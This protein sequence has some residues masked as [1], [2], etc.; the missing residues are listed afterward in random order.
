MAL[1]EGHKLVL[2]MASPGSGSIAPVLDKRITVRDK[3]YM[4]IDENISTKNDDNSFPVLNVQKENTQQYINNAHVNFTGREQASPTVVQQANLKGSNVWA[5]LSV[6]NART[7]TN[8]TTNYSYSGNPENEKTGQNFYRYSDKPRTTTNE[9]TNY[10]YSGNPE[11]EKTGQNFYRYSDKPRTTTNETTL[12]SY[13]GDP[14]GTVNSHNQMNRNQYTGDIIYDNKTGAYY[15]PGTSGVTK[16]SSKSS[17]LIENYIPS[18]NGAVNYQQDALNKIGAPLLRPDDD[19]ISTNGPG[20]L[21]RTAPDGSR[22]TQVDK[23]F[24]GEQRINPNKLFS[25]DTRQTATYQISA[26]KNNGLSVYRDLDKT[27]GNNSI[28]TFFIDQNK[29]N[30]SDYNTSTVKKS[31]DISNNY[32]F[33]FGEYGNNKNINRNAEKV[34]NTHNQIDKNIDNPLLFMKTSKNSNIKHKQS[35]GSNNSQNPTNLEYPGLGYSG[36]ALKANK[37]GVY[38]DYQTKKFSNYS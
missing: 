25:E 33:K 1:I 12:Y 9:T 35:D 4:N 36:S 23:A 26:L 38:L 20:T 11:N 24:I 37:D 15:N 19:S 3:S 7:T 28:P 29:N 32:E 30:Y 14:T 8:E 31:K 13:S 21:H 5:N 17:V 18:A 10:S 22:F 34:F 6:F 27:K 16:W 2:D